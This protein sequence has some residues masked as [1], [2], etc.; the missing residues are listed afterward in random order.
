[1]KICYRCGKDMSDLD[2]LT[3]ELAHQGA[4]KLFPEFEGWV[5]CMGSKDKFL[6]EDDEGLKYMFE[7]LKLPFTV[8]AVIVCARCVANEFAN[9]VVPCVQ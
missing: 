3:G 5:H 2:I 1:M 7:Q 8:G 6:E 9:E 4:V